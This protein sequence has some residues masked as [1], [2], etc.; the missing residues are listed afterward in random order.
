MKGNKKMKEKRFKV[1]KKYLVD[2]YYY[3]IEDHS[4]VHIS[5]LIEIPLYFDS[6][7]LAQKIC[8]LI[9]QEYFIIDNGGVS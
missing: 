8:D 6:E 1:I 3:F 7:Q 5:Q 2:S 4:C 9:N